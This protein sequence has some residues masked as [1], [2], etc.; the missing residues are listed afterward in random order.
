MNT[1]LDAVGRGNPIVS[2]WTHYGSVGG[3]DGG[4]PVPET[5]YNLDYARNCA[6]WAAPNE[7]PSYGLVRSLRENL[8]VVA[9]QRPW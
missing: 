9:R 6:P 1:F 7:Q 2:R 4:I 5:E 3:D 8:S